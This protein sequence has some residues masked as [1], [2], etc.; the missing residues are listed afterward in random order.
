MARPSLSALDAFVA[1]ARHQSFRR[2]ALERGVTPS[3]LSHVIRGLEETLAVRLFNRT[4]RSVRMTAAGERLLNR[5]EPA[6]G[7][8][9]EAIEQVTSSRLR[10][11]GTLRLNVPRNAIE[12]VIRPLIAQ[13]LTAYPEII[14][15]V[16]SDDGLVDIVAAG[17]DAGIRAGQLLAQDMISVPIGGPLRFAVVGSPAYFIDRERPLIPLD[18]HAHAC[19]RRRYPGG[20]FYSWTFARGEESMDV[21]VS[22]P[23][24]ADARSLIVAAALEGIGL[25][26]IHE[27]FVEQHIARGDLV[28]VLEDWC[29]P[30]L[31][32]FLYF[33]GRRHVPAVLRA[34]IEFARVHPLSPSRHPEALIEAQEKPAS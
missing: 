8:I 13:F 22:G 18:L 28:R 14:I 26:H 4:N 25:A 20:A 34:F 11:S 32:F 31:S 9:D 15:E 27:V 21:D 17:F 2:A 23:L 12:L 16:V 3:A 33:P 1:V 7:D 5:I 10:P 6:L 24:I 19:V 30:L 29:P